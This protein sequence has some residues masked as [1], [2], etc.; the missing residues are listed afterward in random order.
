MEILKFENVELEWNEN[1]SNSRSPRTIFFS[2]FTSTYHPVQI[3]FGANFEIEISV[4]LIHDLAYQ[5]RVETCYGVSY[6]GVLFQKLDDQSD[7]LSTSRG[8]PYLT[9][10]SES[11]FLSRSQKPNA[12]IDLQ[13]PRPHTPS[14][15]MNMSDNRLFSRGSR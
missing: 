9:L 11:T 2:H 1:G 6:S 4:T 3:R 15:M 7:T 10:R 5:I 13:T 14:N 12:D 8:T